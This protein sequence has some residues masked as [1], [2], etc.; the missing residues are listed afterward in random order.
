MK[1]FSPF[2]A[3]GAI[4]MAF[5]GCSTVTDLI[6]SKIPESHAGTLAIIVSL[7]EQE[8]YLYRGG[9]RTASSRV[10]SG[11][12]GYRTPIGRFTLSAKTQIIA[13][14]SMVTTLMT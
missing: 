3:L 14:V 8:A 13:P 1:R 10:S 11:R 7:R 6:T 4:F 12:E 5:S 2:Y 9:Y